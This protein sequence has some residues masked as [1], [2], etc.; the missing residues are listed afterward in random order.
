M[1]KILYL[2]ICLLCVFALVAC[3]A[4]DDTQPDDAPST[5]TP[6]DDNPTPDE[7]LLK[8]EGISFEG[9]NLTYDGKEH[10]IVVSGNL[11]E[12]TNVAYTANKATNAGIYN[13][14]ATLSCVGYESKTLNATLKINKADIVGITLEKDTPLL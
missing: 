12:G 11:P 4:P 2:L 7:P 5:D 1:K 13:A 6:A 3:G 8:F 10:S 14:A 9:A